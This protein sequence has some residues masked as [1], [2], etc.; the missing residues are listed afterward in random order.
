M[1]YNLGYACI[2]TKL[3]EKDIFM[4][5]TCKLQT[6]KDKG[7]DYVMGL[8]EKNLCNIMTM[9]KWNVKNN[10]RFLRLSSEIF[11]FASH[12]NYCYSIAAT[13]DLLKKIGD[14]AKANNI[15]LTMHP[16]QHTLLSTPRADVLKN[17][18]LDLKHHANILD[19]MGLDDDSV[20]IIHGGGVYGNKLK[21]LERLKRNFKKLPKN[22]QRRIVL[23][24][25][26]MSYTIEDLL[27]LCEE[28]QIPF[29]IDFHH[30]E[31]NRSSKRAECYFA[32]IFKIWKLRNIKPK[33]HISNS[34]PGITHNDNVCLRRK[35]SDY[36]HRLQPSFIKLLESKSIQSFDSVDIMV[37]AKMKEQ[38]VLHLQKMLTKNKY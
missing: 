1:K 6:L 11:P 36:I 2:N 7:L 21:S 37:E 28:L 3:R 16:G 14:F 8:A 26:E 35:H 13:Y 23:E 17:S 33:V 34:P 31:L 29:V 32:R 15:R 38:A 4:S 10:I 22:V 20:I 18:I 27:P 24:N 9:L 30:D 25:D 12:P 5:R 19:K